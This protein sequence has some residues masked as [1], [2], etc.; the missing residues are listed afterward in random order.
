M[1]LFAPSDAEVD[2]DSSFVDLSS[3]LV[4][5]PDQDALR[6]RKRNGHVFIGE[7]PN[8]PHVLS[9]LRMLIVDNMTSSKD[10]GVSVLEAVLE[11][12]PTAHSSEIGRF[13][14][15]LFKT[16]LLHLITS[17]ALSTST[18]ESSTLLPNI[19]K[20]C[21][22]VA[23]R[24]S[25]GAWS[26]G[27]LTMWQY[28]VQLM[29]QAVDESGSI[30]TFALTAF[31]AAVLQPT[32]DNLFRGLNKLTLFLLA[33]ESVRSNLTSIVHNVT[34]NMPLLLGEVNIDAD[35]LLCMCHQMLRMM[36][37][38]DELLLSNAVALCR[39]IVHKRPNQM[40]VLLAKTFD[41]H[42]KT[43]A[44]VTKAILDSR[45]TLK[46]ACTKAWAAKGALDTKAQA[47]TGRSTRRNSRLSKR[48]K[49]ISPCIRLVY[50]L[51]TQKL[52]Q[53][54]AGKHEQ[55]A[56]FTS[57]VNKAHQLTRTAIR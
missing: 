13:H 12:P 55:R 32:V 54:M 6:Q 2:V 36:E 29:R 45:A 49:V 28:F 24:A 20:L 41:P 15:E 26:N 3:S 57:S 27:H 22:H 25:S 21:G 43:D 44:Q 17:K 9:F 18:T 47:A 23:D 34:S 48:E 37:S 52:K 50:S 39:A 38:G 30:Y 51:A 35:F 5:N 56:R 16:V 1:A 11:A 14:F 46:P 53:D 10:R 4:Y 42:H 40:K 31:S 19:G 7:H 33:H 8:A